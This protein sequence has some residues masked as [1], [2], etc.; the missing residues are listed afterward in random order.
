MRRSSTPWSRP[1]PAAIGATTTARPPS[2]SP[3]TRPA[4]A[5]PCVAD[6]TAASLG[7]A[8]AA[9]IVRDRLDVGVGI[10]LDQR[11]HGGVVGALLG[12]EFRECLLEVGLLLAGKARLRAG[13]EEAADMAA[14]AHARGVRALRDRRFLR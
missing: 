10:G 1:A 7:R 3:R 11:R 6:P 2:T 8:Q 4:R 9:Q 13:A 12:L 5:S 14:G